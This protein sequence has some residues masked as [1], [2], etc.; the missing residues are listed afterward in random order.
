MP[1]YE[2]TLTRR[3][4]ARAQMLDK[5]AVVV[6]APGQEAAKALAEQRHYGYRATAVRPA[7]SRSDGPKP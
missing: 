2:V 6:E 5:I 7:E 1:E 3:A 4:H